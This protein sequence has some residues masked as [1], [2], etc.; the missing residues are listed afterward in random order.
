MVLFASLSNGSSVSFASAS[1][2][3][4]ASRTAYPWVFTLRK[5]GLNFLRTLHLRWNRNSLSC[6]AE[7]AISTGNLN[8]MEANLQ[9]ANK[10]GKYVLPWRMK[11]LCLHYLE[12]AGT[13]ALMGESLRY[14]FWFSDQ[15][16]LLQKENSC[17]SFSLLITYTVSLEL[18]PKNISKVTRC[19]IKIMAS[20]YTQPITTSLHCLSD[21]SMT[22]TIM[23]CNAVGID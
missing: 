8:G 15:Q 10:A 7:K 18:V 9:P 23:Q 3:T 16:L 1:F 20:N 11:E 22:A 5:R 2:A 17:A 21:R 13:M 19:K 14:T 12:L 6:T 4:S